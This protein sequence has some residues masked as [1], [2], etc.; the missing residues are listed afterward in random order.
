MPLRLTEVNYRAQVKISQVVLAYSQATAL[1]A[2]LPRRRSM[3][4]RRCSRGTPPH[5]AG[6]AP[7]AR[8]S[9]PPEP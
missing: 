9:S 7:S 6:R 2:A 3:H 1:C 5:A 4:T 8:A